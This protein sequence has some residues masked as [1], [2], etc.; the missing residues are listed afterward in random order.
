MGF[1][2]AAS[3]SLETIGY[4]LGNRSIEDMRALL[5]SLM[6]SNDQ[7]K[8][9]VITLEPVKT[10]E[11]PVVQ[12]ASTHK[13]PELPQPE[14]PEL[15]ELPVLPD[16][17][18]NKET[19]KQTGAN[20]VGDDADMKQLPVPKWIQDC[21]MPTKGSPPVLLLNSRTTSPMERQSNEMLCSLLTQSSPDSHKRL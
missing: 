14:L 19:S 7:S 17:L 12:T 21:K 4:T 15:P 9:P 6:E 3:R 1:R 2:V 11:D 13:L 16:E 8:Q 18:Q 5:N 20:N 10:S